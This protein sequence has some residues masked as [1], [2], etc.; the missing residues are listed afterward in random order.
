MSCI[1]CEIIGG[2]AEG[3]F[4]Y[5]DERAVAFADL[6]PLEPGHLLVVPR[7]HVENIYGLEDDLAAHLFQVTTRLART[8]KKVLRPDGVTLLQMNERAGGQEVFHF[9]MHIVPRRGGRPLAAL[10]KAARM[11][12]PRPRADRAELERLLSPVRAALDGA[13]Q[14]DE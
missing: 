14:G 9:H 10:F 4:V 8:V 6:F 2:R 1:F 7:R 3:T 13:P 12:V 11:L 5:R